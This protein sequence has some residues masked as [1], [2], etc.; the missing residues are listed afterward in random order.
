MALYTILN[1]ISKLRALFVCFLFVCFFLG[2]GGGWGLLCFF[3][4][5]NLIFFKI[6]PCKA[7]FKRLNNSHKISVGTKMFCINGKL[8]I[9]IFK[10]KELIKK[11]FISFFK[12]K[13]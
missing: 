3:S 4:L 1:L 6:N 7:N 2:G 5:F 11:M 12:I 10:H 8:I 13:N 9:L